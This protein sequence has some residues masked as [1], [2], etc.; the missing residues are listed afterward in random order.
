MPELADIFRLYGDEYIKT[1]SQDMLPSHKR[2]FYDILHC[3]TEVMGGHILQCDNCGH[4]HYVYHSCKNRNCPKCHGEQTREWLELRSGELLPVPYFHCVFTI[5]HE[6]RDIF[7]KKQKVMYSLLMKSAAES[8]IKMARDPRYVGGKIG[9]LA[10]L[11]TWGRDLVYHPHVHCL[12]TGGG[13]SPYGQSWMPARENFFLPI[14]AVS[15]I[16]KGIFLYGIKKK[17]P[18]M[19]IPHKSIKQKWNVN[20]TPVQG[21]GKKVLEYL[22]R[23]IHRI[24]IT[25]ERIVSIHGG[26]ISFRYKDTHDN[27]WKI[28]TLK[29]EEFIRRFLQHVLPQGFHKVRYFGL[30]S[31]SNRKTLQRVRILHLSNYLFPGSTEQEPE[32]VMKEE[33]NGYPVHG[34][35]CPFCHK[36]T[37]H[38]IRTIFRCW[39]SPP[40]ELLS[41]KKA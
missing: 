13:V 34:Q 31:P 7:R 35:S 27:Q 10:V 32:K 41:N 6:M 4:E 5:P 28:M 23:Y 9:V 21:N 12:V 30:W 15:R 36:G 24:A 14:R 2:A 40:Q 38:R 19:T 29:A 26:M 11:H 20:I 37:L 8:L 33:T 17:N 16:F 1:Y 22:S 18:N 39:R 3:R 25:N